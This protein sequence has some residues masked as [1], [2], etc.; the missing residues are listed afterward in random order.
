M[1]PAVAAGT[2]VVAVARPAIR[3]AKTPDVAEELSRLLG[4]SRSA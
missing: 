2:R 3:G 4:D 1:S